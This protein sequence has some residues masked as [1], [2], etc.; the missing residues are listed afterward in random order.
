MSCTHFV[1]AYF[2]MFSTFVP[3]LPNVNTIETI[4]DSVR[5]SCSEE[6]KKT[7]QK[8]PSFTQNVISK[9]CTCD[10]KKFSKNLRV[11]D[12]GVVCCSDLFC[13]FS[14]VQDLNTHKHLLYRYKLYM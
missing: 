1:Y 3:V 11:H 8:L 13:V 14:L 6:A 7:H 9:S 12:F 5:F 2:Q 10:K 4:C